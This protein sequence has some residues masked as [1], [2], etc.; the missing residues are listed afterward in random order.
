MNGALF[1]SSV[2]QSGEAT[3]APGKEIEKRKF[4]RTSVHQ[5][6][7]QAAGAWPN[8]LNDVSALR[9]NHGG[10]AEVLSQERQAQ[11]F[12]LRGVVARK[13]VKGIIGAGFDIE[14]VSAE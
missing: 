11:N 10:S 14:W 1:A 6:D 8:V 4:G 13:Q 9:Q 7:R 2:T 5:H 12:S 3:G